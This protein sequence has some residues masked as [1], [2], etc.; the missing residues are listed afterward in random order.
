MKNNR[1]LVQQ[2]ALGISLSMG[3]TLASQ[4]DFSGTVL[5]INDELTWEI[6]FSG[7]TDSANL[8]TSMTVGDFNGDGITDLALGSPDASSRRGV[9]NTG[10]VSIYF[11][12]PAFKSLGEVITPNG[13]TENF[14]LYGTKQN[15]YLGKQLAAGDLNG[16]GIDDLV[17]VAQQDYSYDQTKVYI[18]YGQNDLSGN[19]NSIEADVMLVRDFMHVS[20]L[21]VGD[22]NADGIDDLVI[23]DN[24][25]NTNGTP[26]IQA[27][28]NIHGAV[29]VMLGRHQWQTVIDLA[30]RADGIITRLNG[31]GV[32][33]I[34]GLAI[35]DVNGDG[36]NDLVMGAS[37]ESND[38]LSL[39][40][41]GRIYVF[42]GRDKL[43]ATI[44]VATDINL[45]LFIQGSR[46]NEQMGETL[47]V[48]DVNGDGIEDILIGGPQAW[49][50]DVPYTAGFGKIELVYGAKDLGQSPLDLLDDADVTL[51]LTPQ[52]GKPNFLTG[53]ALIT[54]DINNDQ[55]EDIIVS[56]PNGFLNG[57]NN[58]W[59]HVVYGNSTL[60]SQIKLDE[61]ANIWVQAPEP[62]HRLAGGKMGNTL[63][64]ADLDANGHLDLV[65]GA[66]NGSLSGKTDNGWTIVLFDPT[67]KT[68]TLVCTV[69]DRR[70]C[71]TQEACEA[72]DGAWNGI[73]CLDPVA[74]LNPV[75]WIL[76]LPAVEV[77]ILG[78]LSY[79]LIL[80]VFS[81]QFELTET[82][83]GAANVMA[84]AR[85]D[86]TTGKLNIPSVFIGDK[87]YWLEL[88]EIVDT[89]PMLF[90]I[91]N[92]GENE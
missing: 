92:F 69:N 24:L 53:Q 84:P 88:Q 7:K 80:D 30:C 41:M 68:T 78:F 32:F 34:E 31:N 63:A 15:E 64:V 42:F 37:K 45:L 35:G 91:G 12:N 27:G 18:L 17:I 70:G 8:A 25:T 40:K 23:S 11:G 43:P 44:D 76:T 67:T 21:A 72:V 90:D 52:F 48:G 56:T 75:S 26:P 36:K 13:V 10:V 81:F 73:Q 82:G 89:S 62:A 19:M 1:C 60:P 3:L 28:R 2:L 33:Q 59:V 39:E 49:E 51:T 20:A 57:G 87:N 9:N 4:A 22:I 54:A 16:D 77:P 58:G 47:A 14:A 74:T 65:M 38:S 61:S 71:E 55:V 66:P 46:V 50:A 83:P 6:L 86:T 79:T 85:Y 5:E 29:Y